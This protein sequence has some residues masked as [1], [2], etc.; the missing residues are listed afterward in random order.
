MDLKR[1]S[2]GGCALDSCSSG[3][4][5]ADGCYERDV[6]TLRFPLDNTVHSPI[7]VAVSPLSTTARL[8]R[9]KRYTFRSPRS[10]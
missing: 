10:A 1:K 4:G 6:G 3:Y 8:Q 7:P 2:I 9:A 5:P